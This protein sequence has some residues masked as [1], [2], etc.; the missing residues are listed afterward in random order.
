MRFL[1]RRQK[2]H[3]LLLLQ[4]GYCVAP[5]TTATSPASAIASAAAPTAAASATTSC[6]TGTAIIYVSVNVEVWLFVEQENDFSE[7]VIHIENSME[8]VLVVCGLGPK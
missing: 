1:V 6:A 3:G 2:P 7:S 4:R 8:Y 5:T